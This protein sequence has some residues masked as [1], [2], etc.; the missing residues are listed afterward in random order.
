MDFIILYCF[1]KRNQSNWTLKVQPLSC[2]FPS[3]KCCWSWQSIQTSPVMASIPHSGQHSSLGVGVAWAITW[4]ELWARWELCTG[5]E[6]RS[7]GLL[8]SKF[9]SHCASRAAPMRRGEQAHLNQCL[10][11]THFWNLFS[12][13]LCCGCVKSLEDANYFCWHTITHQY[14]Q[15][16][17]PAITFF[18]ESVLLK[19]YWKYSPSPLISSLWSFI[20]MPSSWQ[21]H[22]SAQVEGEDQ[23]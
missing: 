13:Q 7:S 11:W 20:F 22:C 2:R 8:C 23:L 6:A 3:A 18:F 4:W 21:Q 14:V 1:A 19:V 12:F 17:S 15:C 10:C 16:E 5:M 9:L